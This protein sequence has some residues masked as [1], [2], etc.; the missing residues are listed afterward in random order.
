VAS[1]L[2]HW[3]TLKVVVVKVLSFKRQLFMADF[4]KDCSIEMFGRDTG[5]L[6]GL[7]TED[8]FKAGYA[9]PVICEGCGCIWVDHEGQRVKP[10]EDKE[11]W[12]RC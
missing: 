10:S 4:C 3:K 6:K 11:S 9:M 5:D 2:N 8:D 12:E 1:S 7:I